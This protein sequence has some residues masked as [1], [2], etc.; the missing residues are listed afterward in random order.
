MNGSPG[1]KVVFPGDEDRPALG[2]GTW[3]LG[4]DA[5]SADAEVAAVR[6]AM[7]LGYRV[8][9]TAEMYGEGGAETVVGRAVAEALGAGE[10]SRDEL[11]IV[12][13]VYPHNAGRR[14]A[15]E[16]CERSLERLGLDTLDA[17]LLHWPGSVPL[18]ETIAAFEALQDKGRIR[19]WGVSNFDLDRMQAL[20]R[21]PGGDR[22]AINQIYYSLGERGPAFELLPWQ[23]ARQIVTMAYSP[24]DQGALSRNPSLQQIAARL[25]STASAVA[26]A[27]LTGQ[28][29]VMAIPKS[30]DEGRLRD[31]RR[32]ADIRLSADDLVEIDRAFPPPRRRSPLAML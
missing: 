10:V 4:E 21:L 18:A 25:E 28:E 17:Y 12:S 15:L 13:K 1:P 8:I 26:L 5:S 30:V 24:L 23:Q 14:S 6:R 22:C 2:L 27:W 20:F 32:A 7:Q 19:Q 9:D 3:R 31:N 16:A 29:G 11:F